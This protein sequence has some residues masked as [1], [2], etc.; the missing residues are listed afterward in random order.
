[1]PVARVSGS[2]GF[3]ADAALGGDGVDLLIVVDRCQFE[4]SA[5]SRDAKGTPAAERVSCQLRRP[6]SS[7]RVR[8]ESRLTGLGDA[9][10]IPTAAP[11]PDASA[12]HATRVAAPPAP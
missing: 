8:Y 9:T 7:A 6:R 11:P 5:V 1:M 4:S 12:P 10:L 2:A 3:S